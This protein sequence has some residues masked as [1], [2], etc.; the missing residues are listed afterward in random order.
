MKKNNKISLLSKVMVLS[1]GL[2]LTLTACGKQNDSK[3]QQSFGDSSLANVDSSETNSSVVISSSDVTSKEPVVSSSSTAP[4]SSSSSSQ[5]APKETGT[6]LTVSLATQATFTNNSATIYGVGTPGSDYTPS[7]TLKKVSTATDALSVNNGKTRF[8]Q[9]DTLENVASLGGIKSLTVHGGDGY[10]KLY[11]GYSKDKM[12]EFLESESNSGDRIFENIPNMNYFKLEGKYDNYT[13]D[14]SSIEITYTRNEA[15]ELV[16]GV[17]TPIANVT[18]F[19]GTFVKTTNTLVVRDDSITLNGNEYT[20]TGIVYN[21]A[22]IYANSTKQCVSVKFDN[23]NTSIV[24][25]CADRYSSL[26]GT[27]TKVIEATAITMFKNG[28]EVEENDEYNRFEMNVGDTFTFTATCDA[29]PAQNVTINCCDEDNPFGVD[30]FAG[31]YTVANGVVEMLDVNGVL[32]DGE[33]FDLEITNLE[34]VTD[35]GDYLVSYSDNSSVFGY[36]NHSDIVEGTLSASGNTL[37]FTVGDIQGVI[38]AASHELSLVLTTDDYY[39]FGEA[40]YTVDLDN[41]LTALYD[42][43]TG[44]VTANDA[45]DFYMECL[46]NNNLATYYYVHVNEYIEAQVTLN[47]YYQE[48][49]VNDEYQVRATVNADATN[50]TLSYESS[51]TAIATVTNTGLVKAKATGDA[52][53]T[54]STVDG[55]SATLTIKVKA[56]AVAVNYAFDDDEGNTHSL[57]YIENTSITIDGEYVFNHTT[58]N[59]YAYTEDSS[60]VITFRPAGGTTYIDFVDEGETLFGVF[61]PIVSYGTDC[62][63]ISRS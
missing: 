25:N 11:A 23:E 57:A 53:I 3:E 12:Y 29:V 50:K 24:V 60:V 52:Y 35:E 59:N 21:G 4:S 32:N 63:E 40:S 9:G 30:Q 37:S 18:V 42:A 15:H 14:I 5:A 48:L 2:G 54:V 62:F 55:F 56:A 34:V 27:Y 1:L 51:N 22:L 47:S 10:F 33:P 31:K 44:I 13:C 17:A 20:Y 43:N 58:A 49:N 8:R 41:K 45:G 16:D 6:S 39:A 7:F 19:K 38:D 28:V 36:P 26:S 46:T 61:G